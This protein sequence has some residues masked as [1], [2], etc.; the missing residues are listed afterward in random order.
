M[1]KR[2]RIFFRIGAWAS[3]ATGGIHLFG[4]FAPRP[5]P[6]NGTEAMLRHLLTTYHTDLGAGFSRTTMDFLKGFSLS[7]ALFLLWVGVLSLL[8]LRR[9]AQGAAWLHRVSL[10]NAIL[11]AGLL[12]ISLIYFFLPPIVCVAVVFLGFAGA[13][14][15]SSRAEGAP[16]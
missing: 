10:V 16:S 6:A 9:A 13:A 1:T 11:A 14:L 7:F 15:P 8:A 5:T 3:V 4:H 2:Q 12:A